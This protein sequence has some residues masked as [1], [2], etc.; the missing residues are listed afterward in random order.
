MSAFIANFCTINAEAGSFD[1]PHSVSKII[2]LVF[3]IFL[4]LLVRDPPPSL[5]L[6]AFAF[7]AKNLNNFVVSVCPSVRLA[8]RIIAASTERIFIKFGVGTSMKIY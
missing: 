2:F 5:F 7:L 4:L 6:G 3:K 8:A 1:G